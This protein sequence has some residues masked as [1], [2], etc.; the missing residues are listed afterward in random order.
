M[1]I[2]ELNSKIFSF[3]RETINIHQ[4]KMNKDLLTDC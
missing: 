3:E 2:S 4:K 1:D